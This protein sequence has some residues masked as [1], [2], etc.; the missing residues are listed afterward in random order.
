MTECPW[1]ILESKARVIGQTWGFTNRDPFTNELLNIEDSPES[2][3]KR[4]TYLTKKIKKGSTTTIS[5]WNK[6][7]SYG[8]SWTKTGSYVANWFRYMPAKRSD[9][10]HAAWCEGEREAYEDYSETLKLV[11]IASDLPIELKQWTEVEQVS[12]DEA[13]AEQGS[14]EAEAEADAEQASETLLQASDGFQI[15]SAYESESESEVMC[16]DYYADESEYESEEEDKSENEK[17]ITEAMQ[18]AHYANQAAQSANKASIAATA[19][20]SLCEPVELIIKNTILRVFPT[21]EIYRLKKNGTVKEISNTMNH[22]GSR[23]N[24]IVIEKKQ[25]MRGVIIAHAFLHL[26]LTPSFRNKLRY[27]N[28]NRMDCCITN[29]QVL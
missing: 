18:T 28:G 4:L 17:I 15:V 7:H 24:V 2:R 22:K 19:L 25:Y 23:S 8:V 9:W 26:K 13:E 10:Y 20:L 5:Q 12:D 16:E 1:K 6:R 11:F 3:I 29:L 21:G 14:A 27:I